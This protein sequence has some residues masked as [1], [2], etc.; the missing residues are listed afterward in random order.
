MSNVFVTEPYFAVKVTISDPVAG[1]VTLPSFVITSVLDEVHVMAVPCA[2]VAGRTR[3]VFSLINTGSDTAKAST[4]TVKVLVVV[5]LPF[6]TVAVR[7]TFVFA[8]GFVTVAFP[9]V[10]LTT[11]SLLDVH[12]TLEA[13]NPSV[14]RL[15]SSLADVGTVIC[16]ASY[17]TASLSVLCILL[18]QIVRLSDPMAVNT[19]TRSRADVCSFCSRTTPLYVWLLILMVM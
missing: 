5:S 19:M 12:V 3:F 1:T 9:F 4:D 10:T 11:L 15:K 18:P 14:V 13:N 17:S 6:F 8:S 16:E 2:V 7:V